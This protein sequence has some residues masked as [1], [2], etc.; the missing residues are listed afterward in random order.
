MN[1]T[2]APA[3]GYT[4]GYDR[5]ARLPGV[6]SLATASRMLDMPR[7]QTLA[8]LARWRA[9]K[10][11]KDIRD[12]LDPIVAERFNSFHGGEA[13]T[14]N[15]ILQSLVSV[16]DDIT[17]TYFDM[18]ELCEQVAMLFLA[19][20]ETSASALSW[21]LYLLSLDQEIQDRAHVEA[22][23]VLG[24]REAEFS[25]IRQLGL[26]RNVFAETMRL[27]PPVPF[28]PRE[29]K[30][31]C[32]IR[33]KTAEKGSIISISPWMIQR[34]RHR[35]KNP[36]TFDP[37]RFDRPETRE[38]ERHCY[39]PFSKGPRVCLGASFALQEAAIILS[40]L[41]R[42]YKFSPV[43]GFTPKLTGRLTLRSANGIRLRLSKRP[44]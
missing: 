27:F 43:P 6:F 18:R 29:A 40:G 24:E 42:R 2:S 14:H 3:L 7:Q 33:H 22:A 25:D 4:S 34:H 38:A 36:D 21:S 23:A 1:L 26:I 13:Q 31:T 37:D 8:Y 32:P 30:A 12:I 19:G 11:A 20:H 28:L 16:K 35:W 41:V 15:D 9:R 10:S 17:N 44:A 39:I 5:L